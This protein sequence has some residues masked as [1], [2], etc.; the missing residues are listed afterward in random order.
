MANIDEIYGGLKNAIERGVSLENA[1]ISF[2]NAGYNKDDVEEAARALNSN[3]VI[4]QETESSPQ[5]KAFTKSDKPVSHPTPKPLPGKYQE[6][7]S[8]PAASGNWKL[9]TLVGVL[10]LLIVI[11]VLVLIFRDKIIGLFS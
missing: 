10:V 11:F 7:R 2:I 9:Y 6:V 3:S 4:A 1:K 5:P 8:S